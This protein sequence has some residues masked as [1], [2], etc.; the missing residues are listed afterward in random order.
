MLF[1]AGD[2]VPRIPLLD[3]VGNGAIT[4]PK[5][6]GVV[7]ENTGITFGKILIINVCEVAHCPTFGVKV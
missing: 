3:V 2:H 4:L 1:K 6:T 7:I 5:Q